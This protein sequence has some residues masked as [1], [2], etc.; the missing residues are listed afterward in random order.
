MDIS[1]DVMVETETEEDY[2]DIVEKILR[3]IA[4]NDLF[5]KLEKYMWK[6]REFGF[7]GV[8]IR[9]DG[10]KM[11]N[12]KVQ[13]VIDW[14]VSKS[15][16]DIQKFLRLANYYR[17]F[18]K[19]FASVA[20]LL[21]EMTRKEIKWNWGERLQKAFEKLKEKFTTEP[22]LVTLDLVKKIKVKADILDFVIG[23]VLLIKYEDKKQRLVDYISELLNKTK[24]NYEIYDKE[25]LAIIRYLE[26]WR[27]FL[28]E[29][30]GQFEI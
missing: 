17:W 5:V 6:I 16:K 23:E 20:K 18:V 24:K 29:A 3:K 10:V 1:H 19:N 12:E 4:E 9:P 21:H 7:L 11:E 28:E 2:D 26:V 25:M 14:L 13:G 8:M 27:Y 15:I 30:K 22:V